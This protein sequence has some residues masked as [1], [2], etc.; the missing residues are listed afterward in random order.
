MA[1]STLIFFLPSKVEILLWP[2]LKLVIFKASEREIGSVNL[3][4]TIFSRQKT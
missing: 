2:F 1:V 3:T 4:Q